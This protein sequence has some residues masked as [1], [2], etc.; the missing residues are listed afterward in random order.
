LICPNCEATNSRADNFCWRCGTPLK[1]EAAAA[2]VTSPSATPGTGAPTRSPQA[3]RSEYIYGGPGAGNPFVGA[4]VPPPTPPAAPDAYAPPAPSWQPTLSPVGRAGRGPLVA[5]LAIGGALLLLL[6]GVGAVIFAGNL[7]PQAAAQPTPDASVPTPVRGGYQPT[8]A[9]ERAVIAAVE[10]NNAAQIAA[11]RTLDPHALD[12]TM[13]GQA[14]Q[15]NQVMIQDLES[16]GLYQVARLI[17]I[18]YQQ[19][20]F[21]GTDEAS[22][23][24]V[25]QWESTVYQRSNNQVAGRQPPQTLHEIYYLTRTN[26]QW[27]VNQVD[28]QP[29]QQGTPEPTN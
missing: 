19:P 15:D 2:R 14:L 12:G 22:I 28:I 1:P 9:D 13:T 11:L 23:R 29:Q 10:A 6:L 4:P 24:T 7:R 25:E 21:I 27:V 17:R 20:R 5:V 18:E 26:G 3:P 16:H 8:T